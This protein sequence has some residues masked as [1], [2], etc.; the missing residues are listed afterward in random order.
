MTN[1]I[2]IYIQLC[3]GFP[4]RFPANRRQPEPRSNRLQIDISPRKSYNIPVFPIGQ[5]SD[6]PAEARKPIR[7]PTKR[8]D[9][10]ADRP[11]NARTLFQPRRNQ[12]RSVL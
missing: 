9:R 7:M 5:V 3:A 1:Y 10:H 6:D 8:P 2:K 11:A 12:K 4:Y